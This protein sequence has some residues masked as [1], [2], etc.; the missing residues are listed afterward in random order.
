M[1]APSRPHSRGLGQRMARDAAPRVRPDILGRITPSRS[2]VYRLV[3]IA[4]VGA[5]LVALFVVFRERAPFTSDSWSF[6]ELSREIFSDF[7]RINTWRQF[8]FKQ[9]YGVSFPPLWPLLIAVFNA[10]LDQGV[11]GGYSLNFAIT[12]L[13]LAVLDRLGQRV[14]DNPYA[15]IVLYLSLAANLDYLKEV[16]AGMSLPL[17]ILLLCVVWYLLLEREH[18]GAGRVVAIG[19]LCGAIALTRFD[20]WLPGVA[21]GIVV[22]LATQ[23]HRVGC[24]LAYGGAYVLAISP[25]A[26]YSWWR[27]GKMFVS[28]NSRTVLAASRTTVSEYHPD[29][30]PTLFDAPVAWTVKTV[31][32]GRLVAQ[33]LVHSA[34]ENTVVLLCLGGLVAWVVAA[35]VSGG[36]IPRSE[37]TW[38]LAR[39]AQLGGV[40]AVLVGVITLT[41]YPMGRYFSA[42]LL[43]VCLGLILIVEEFITSARPGRM[44]RVIA[45]VCV[46]SIG[47]A[48]L[49]HGVELW[50]R[51]ASSQ[52][53]EGVSH[54]VTL[55]PRASA[56]RL[57]ELV[58]CLDSGRRGGRLLV[59]DGLNPF[60]FGALTGVRTVVR[61]SNLTR[62]SFPALTQE[63]EVLWVLTAEAEWQEGI[64]AWYERDRDCAFP[65][66]R[67]RPAAHSRSLDE[68][69]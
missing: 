53:R 56:D 15:G 42:V 2:E 51:A 55:D 29:A 6:Y 10:V 45:W 64:A 65:L 18:V 43:Y 54:I 38:R 14:F 4:V 67:R 1:P 8:E 58:R 7:Y 20:F 27:F 24:A 39:L 3:T 69:R 40:M 34:A 23:R 32:N 11:Y 46:L 17:A 13:T 57:E 59:L 61:P 9:E 60:A 28:D 36:S 26:L 35:R 47:A 30:L 68:R 5:G 63:F 33:A 50:K 21:M 66:Y 41:G 12:A 16:M 48:A 62:Q 49:G 37:A 31:L 22:V 19:V 52:A 25:W 44:G